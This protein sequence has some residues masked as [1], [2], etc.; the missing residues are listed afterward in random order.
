MMSKLTGKV[1][2][3]LL[4]QLLTT[5]LLWRLL[6]VFKLNYIILLNLKI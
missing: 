4:L 1:Q 5:L 2:Y 3:D 6:E